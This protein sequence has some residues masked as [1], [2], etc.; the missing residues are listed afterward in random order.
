MKILEVSY[1]IKMLRI[2]RKRSNNVSLNFEQNLSH[3]LRVIR[4]SI[5][6]KKTNS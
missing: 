6:M 5:V 2:N 3:G 4:K 1:A